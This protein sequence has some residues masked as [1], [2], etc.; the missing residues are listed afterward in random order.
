V[1]SMKT[2]APIRTEVW[3]AT[4]LVGGCRHAPLPEARTTEVSA[5]VTC[6]VCDRVIRRTMLRPKSEFPPMPTF[7]AWPENGPR[8]FRLVFRCP[9]CG[10]RNAHGGDKSHPGAGDGPRG[11]HCQCWSCYQIE[12]V[13]AAGGNPTKDPRK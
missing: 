1:I 3:R 4:H 9:V 10:K 7:E 6:R 5:L 12:E 8:G 2:F 13:R 11:S